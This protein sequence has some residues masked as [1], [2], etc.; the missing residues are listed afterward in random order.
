MTLPTFAIDFARGRHFPRLAFTR[1]ST[2]TYDDRLGVVRTAAANMPRLA[3]NPATFAPR[4]FLSEPGATNQ[5]LQSYLLGN[6]TWLKVNATVSVDVV[7]APDGLVQGDKLVDSATN[8]E[9]AAQQTVAAIQSNV[10]SCFS[11]WARAVELNEFQLRVSDGAGNYHNAIFN[12][13]TKAVTPGVVGTGVSSRAYMIEYP[14]KGFGWFRCVIA[15]TPATAAANSVVQINLRKG[16]TNSYAG[17]GEGMYFWGAQFETGGYATSYL[18]TVAAAV[19][20]S[21]DSA[22]LTG[23]SDFYHTAEG[24]LFWEGI[25][26]GFNVSDRCAIFS[27]NTANNMIQIGLN[28][29]T[30]T[31]LR[32]HINSG[33]AVQAD[34]VLGT[35]LARATPYRAALAWKL[36]DV[37]GALNGVLSAADT[38]ATMPSGIDRLAVGSAAGSGGTVPN[39]AHGKVLY[40][41]KRLTDA[42]L[43][44]LTAA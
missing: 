43:Q 38:S 25:F 40:F 13:F 30:P 28:P 29:S 2:G 4:G 8:G 15:G 11:V 27:D 1:G 20:R 36:N 41:P 7:T 35:S 44:M 37:R 12:L 10:E 21:A 9:H 14:A 16:G 33:G 23:V 39:A 32:G 31:T 6:A 24:T 18:A 17:T 26:H 22:L 3:H 5:C 42:E 19:T 34:L